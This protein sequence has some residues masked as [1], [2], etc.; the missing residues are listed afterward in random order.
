MTDDEEP[1][2][3]TFEGTFTDGKF[4]GTHAGMR[5]GEPSPTGTISLSH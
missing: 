3:F 5:D 4:E 2:P 1:R